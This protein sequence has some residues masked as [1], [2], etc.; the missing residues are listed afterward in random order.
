LF[1]PR[2]EH[3]RFC[4]ARCRTAWNR[5]KLGD[6]AP[7]RNALGWSVTAMRDTAGLLAGLAGDGSRAFAVIGEMVWWVTIVDATLVRHHPDAYDGVL[8]GTGPVRRREIE[9]TLGG[10]RFVR[11]RMR[12]DAGCGD[13]IDPAPGG[14]DG[15]AAAW[16]WRP[17]AEP[18]LGSLPPRGRAWELSRH[19]A[20]QAHVAGRGIGETFEVVTAFLEA[21]ADA[22]AQALT[23]RSGPGTVVTPVR[24]R[25]S[26][27]ARA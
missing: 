20:Y 27:A 13:L 22:A 18:P 25:R 23:P 15:L 10:L 8:A 19:Q 2:R 16:R 12:G 11:N 6:P 7:G 5:D 17:A 9:G 14:D 3:A 24:D 21:A 1:E 26:A 4:S